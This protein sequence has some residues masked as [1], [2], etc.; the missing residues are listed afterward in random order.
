MRPAATTTRRSRRVAILLA[1]ACAATGVMTS[2]GVVTATTENLLKNAGFEKPR[3]DPGCWPDFFNDAEVPGWSTTDDFSA[4]EVWS[5]AECNL[6]E[7]SD[8]KQEAFEGTYFV[9][10]NANSDSALYQDIATVPGDTISWRIAHRARITGPDVMRVLAGPAGGTGV[11]GLVPL[12]PLRNNGEPTGRDPQTGDPDIS[13]ESDAWGVWSGTYVVPQGQTL[14]RFGFKAISSPYGIS[15]GNFLDGIEFV[16][17]NPQTYLDPAV[18]AVV[19]RSGSIGR[20]PGRAIGRYNRLLA[21]WK[22]ESPDARHEL[23][24]FNSRSFRRSVNDR[25]VAKVA[26]LTRAQLDPSG[27]TPLYDA[28]VRA[29]RVTH[30]AHPDT[31]VT[32]AI[33]TD[34][35]D[36]ASTTESKRS[37][38]TLIARMQTDFGWTFVYR[39]I[40]LK[41]LQ[42]AVRALTD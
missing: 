38:A 26:P 9:E 28:I 6:A 21:T 35:E 11:D 16:G 23:F 12:V 25:E 3:T 20:D 8:G 13:D 31:D 17:E 18:A 41:P 1:L 42:A 24:L 4:I 15:V 36:N 2:G 22:A 40:S 39:G 14:T 37:V 19:D 5:T 33:V 7:F 29:I 10:L 34:G 32:F 30:R 27:E